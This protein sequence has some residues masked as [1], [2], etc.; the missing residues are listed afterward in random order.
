MNDQEHLTPAPAPRPHLP[1]LALRIKT[2]ME[3]GF[4]IGKIARW[5]HLPQHRV[6][7]YARKINKNTFPKD[8]PRIGRPKLHRRRHKNYRPK[9]H[10]WVP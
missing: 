8:A 10:G 2:L 6:L 4:S 3:R 9:K 5:I 1:P 7:F